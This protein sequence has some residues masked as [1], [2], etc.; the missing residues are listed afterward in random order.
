MRDMLDL[1]SDH[2]HIER[3]CFSRSVVTGGETQSTHHI[4]AISGER[5]L[6]M[7][8]WEPVGPEQ[9]IG[10]EHCRWLYA[11]TSETDFCRTG[12][13][14]MISSRPR[15]Q[16]EPALLERAFQAQRQYLEACARAHPPFVKPGS[17]QWDGDR[18]TAEYAQAE[19]G[20][21]SVK[22]MTADG[23][24]APESVK[25]QVLANLKAGPQHQKRTP[26]FSRSEFQLLTAAEAEAKREAARPA[27][28]SIEAEIIAFHQARHRERV[29]K[30]IQGSVSRDDQGR[31]SAMVLDSEPACH[32]EFEYSA[33]LPAPLAHRIRTFIDSAEA[34]PGVPHD[35]TVIHWARLSEQRL[36]DTAF[37]PWSLMQPGAFV[38]GVLRPDGSSF[39]PDRQEAL[40]YQKL[41]Q[42]RRGRRPTGLSPG[43]AP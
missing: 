15:E 6:L 24:E 36:S 42:E 34:K 5:F 38:H 14:P 10:P 32:M 30:G 28:G 21:F 17:I 1:L 13:T 31:V 37:D 20:E 2:L 7:V 33:E 43:E 29:R 18:F 11:R 3:I 12:G 23:H 19:A 8:L 39:V 27:P 25:A 41:L 35:E 16:T 26:V 9:K 22:I 40:L 4:G